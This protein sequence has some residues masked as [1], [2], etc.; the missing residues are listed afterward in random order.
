[1]L[2]DAEILA[3]LAAIDE[4]RFFESASYYAG[5]GGVALWGQPTGDEA[6]YWNDF[7]DQSTRTI[8]DP[9]HSID[10]GFEPGGWY[11]DNTAKP[12][13]YTAL[14]MRIMPALQANWPVNGDVVLAY[15]D[16]WVEHGAL[17]QPDDCAPSGS[18]YGVD[19]GPDGMGG[20]IA[21]G[22]R[23]PELDGNNAN[24]GNRSRPFGECMLAD[25][26]LHLTGH[27][28]LTG[29]EQGIHRREALPGGRPEA[30]LRP[31]AA[32]TGLAR[33][34]QEATGRHAQKNRKNPRRF[35]SPCRPGRS[36]PAQ[37]GARMQT[38]S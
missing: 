7:G 33:M 20:S 22:G 13:Q 31:A 9:Y 14:L 37:G 10:G 17:T 21:G 25:D 24:G 15:A 1:M 12:T 28:P 6:A 4:E 35:P 30:A 29:A 34:V 16:R 3:D 2:A 8:R 26:F 19:Y 23:V 38:G 32:L 36:R 11:Q 18:E 5:E 27:D